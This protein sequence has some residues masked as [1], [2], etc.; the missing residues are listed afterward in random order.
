M[1]EAECTHIVA[2][3]TLKELDESK[4]HVQPQWV[5]DSLNAGR[6]K[7][8]APYKPGGSAPPHL[9]PFVEDEDEE[10]DSDSDDEA[11]APSPK[12]EKEAKDMAKMLMS[13]KAKRLYGRMQHGRERKQAA[14]ARLRK[15]RELLAARA[16]RQ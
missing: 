11:A 13:K 14:V 4:E 10:E 12:P 6:A 15:R 16:S 2:D 5:I 9:S 8:C 3:R 1:D 7:P